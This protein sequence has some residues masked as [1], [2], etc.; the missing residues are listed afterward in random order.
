MSG[1]FGWPIKKKINI[2]LL[3]NFIFMSENHITVEAVNHCLVDLKI[4]MTIKTIRAIFGHFEILNV[5]LL[6]N[7]IFVLENHITVVAVPS[8]NNQEL[9]IT[10]I[11]PF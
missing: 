8:I 3:L 4:A 1:W 10:D 9:I 11:H 2:V 7:F 6:L 5:V